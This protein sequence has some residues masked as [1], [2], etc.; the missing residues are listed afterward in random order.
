MNEEGRRGSI[1]FGLRA[2]FS[3]LMITFGHRAQQ[4]GGRSAVQPTSAG[5]SLFGQQGIL[6]SDSWPRAGPSGWVESQ[7][8]G[9]STEEGISQSWSLAVPAV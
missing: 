2:P 4:E 6:L 5:T 8:S 7:A 9:T 3:L 1:C